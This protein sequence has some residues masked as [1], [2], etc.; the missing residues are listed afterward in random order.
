MSASASGFCYIVSFLSTRDAIEGSYLVPHRLILGMRRLFF[1]SGVFSSFFFQRHDDDDDD[2]QLVDQIEVWGGA[3]KAAPKILCG[4]YTYHANH[5]TK[6]KV[7]A[8]NTMHS[9]KCYTVIR[10]KKLD[11]YAR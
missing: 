9:S 4:I 2:R 11:I 8:V 1:F 5:K 10:K 6:V 7:S 3:A